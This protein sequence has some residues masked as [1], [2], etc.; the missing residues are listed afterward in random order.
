MAGHDSLRKHGW[1][2]GHTGEGY[3]RRLEANFD[4]YSAEYDAS[5]AG[6]II[7]GYLR[8]VSTKTLESLFREDDRV[9]EVGC[10]T[11]I[12]TIEMLKRGVHVH[13]VDISSRMIERLSRKAEE[14]GLGHMLSV[15]RGRASGIASMGKDAGLF[16]GV[17][18][19]FGAFSSEPHI[20]DFISGAHALLKPGGLLVAGF[21]NRFCLFEM[22]LYGMELRRRRLSERLRGLSTRGNCRFSLE[23]R[24]YSV[25]DFRRLTDGMFSTVMVKGLP[26]LSPPPDFARRLERWGGLLPLLLR[27]DERVNGLPLL[28]RLGDYSLVVAR[29]KMN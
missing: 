20:G 18:T 5:I 29:K 1:P 27:L 13:A 11:G 12:E 17:V 15:S 7:E 24:S 9:L 23:T 3:Y 2:D 6:N 21:W 26:V 8:S 22:L 10:G 4:W 25:H 19:T 16:D 28:N 14:A